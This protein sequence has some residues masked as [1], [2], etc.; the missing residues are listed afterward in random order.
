M[1]KAKAKALFLHFKSIDKIRKSSPEEL[2]AVKGITPALA[3]K[4][5]EWFEE[6]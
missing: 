1:G 5:R 4:I 6:N 3:E 2:C